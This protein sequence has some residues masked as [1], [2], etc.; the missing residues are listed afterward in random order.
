MVLP[1]P[2]PI[3]VAI[4][5]ALAS[6]AAG[7]A[8]SVVETDAGVDAEG[9][10]QRCCVSGR[11]S[12]CYCPPRAACN[13]G[14]FFDCGD[15][16]C[17][18]WPLPPTPLP[19]GGC[20]DGGAGTWERCCVDG[21]I[22]MCFCPAGL[23]CNYGDFIDCGDGTCEVERGGSGPRCGD[24]GTPSVYEVCCDHEAEQLTTCA[25]PGGL[26]AGASFAT[27]AMGRCVHADT[28][29]TVSGPDPGPFFP[30]CQDGRITSCSCGGGAPCDPAPFTPCAAGTCVTFDAVCPPDPWP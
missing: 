15:G 20:R 2:S 25:C 27:C 17:Q 21:R 5:V 3:L 1:R 10:W 19:P 11:I 8:T 13:Y 26:C 6:P 22:S 4:L 7:C 28:R 14:M 18:D 30:C 9:S 24:A 23:A 29:C 12:T 16:T